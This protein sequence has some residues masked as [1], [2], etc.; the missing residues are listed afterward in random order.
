MSVHALL[1]C[2]AALHCV[3]CHVVFRRW[4]REGKIRD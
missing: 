2:A 3:L 1:L 4:E